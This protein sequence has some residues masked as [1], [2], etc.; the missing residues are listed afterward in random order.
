MSVPVSEKSFRERYLALLEEL[1][2]NPR[3]L[4]VIES[5]SHCIALA[6]PGSG[7]TKTITAKVAR[8][9]Y[10]EVPHPRGVACITY[11][12]ECA[13]EIAL[14]LS[15][16][17]IE[18]SS[19]FFLG[20]VHSFCFNHIARPFGA[21]GGHPISDQVAEEGVQ[22]ALK[23]QALK[24]AD[25][26][27][28]NS[29]IKRFDAFRREPL[30]RTESWASEDP[31]RSQVVLHYERALQE[32]GA[33][34]FDE[35][36]RI[37]VTLV[38]T[39]DWV[40]KVIQAKFPVIV[41]DEYQDLGYGLHKLVTK[42]QESGVR[43]I[44]VGDP[45]QSIY[46]F[47]GARPALL[48]DLYDRHLPKGEAVALT[49]NYRCAQRI[50]DLSVVALGQERAY[51]AHRAD[52]G[53]VEP[54]I[55]A[56]G[57]EAQAAYAIDVL[58]PR[59]EAAGIS[60]GEIGLL[61]RDKN[62][63]KAI[64]DVL[65]AKRMSFRGG[66]DVRYPKTP[67]T[68]MIELAALWSIQGLENDEPRLSTVLSRWRQVLNVDPSSSIGFAAKSKFINFLWG[69]RDPDL[70]FSEWLRGLCDLGIAEMLESVPEKEREQKAFTT[71][72]EATAQE[73]KL[74]GWSLK[75]FASTRLKGQLPHLI[76]IH[77]SKGLEYDAAI[78]MGLEGL[79]S[80]VENEERR[81]LYVAMTRARKVVHLLWSG[82]TPP[83]IR[84]F[85]KS[86]GLTP[87]VVDNT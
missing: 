21:I 16:L 14:R 53:F 84:S 82:E 55:I 33:T 1:K 47:T 31:R 12:T 71:L 73:G 60:R 87:F 22:K 29:S 51:E 2:D 68:D 36:V 32:H 79:P 46:S 48:Q 78:I 56:G 40:G 75:E 62:A 5:T 49:K 76:T 72:I 38:H 57:M 64:A 17:G 27:T 26:D 7:K 81:K 83:L 52:D 23:Q 28:R 6:G 3:Q 74:L 34:D 86:A 50:I 69:H 63:C 41:V 4:D 19:R 30:S 13:S 58:I 59:L 9:L 39:Q 44:A 18:P 66:K 61:Y 15:R 77:S 43:L 11:S 25:F 80:K 70:A 37:A 20:T 42:L 67:L 10:E 24:L 8:L 35:M 45:D 85:I 65:N 54:H